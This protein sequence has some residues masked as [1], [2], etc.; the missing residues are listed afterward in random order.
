MPATVMA[1]ARSTGVEEVSP[2]TSAGIRPAASGG[3]RAVASRKR[4]RTYAAHLATI[5][6]SASNS[7]GPEVRRT[8]TTSSPGATGASRPR[9]RTCSCHC[10]LAQ[11]ASPTSRIGAADEL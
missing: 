4:A 3:S 10:T 9:A 8:A 5:G 2:T 11:L 1:S 6:A 7:G